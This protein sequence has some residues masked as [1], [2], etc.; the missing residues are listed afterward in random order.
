MSQETSSRFATIARALPDPASASA[1]EELARRFAGLYGLSQ[2]SNYIFGS[3]LGPFYVRG[4]HH[5]L[6]RFVYFGPHTSDESLRLAFLSG[7]DH[8]D[9]RGTFGLLHFI[10]RLAL[11][12]GLGQG[13][14]LAFF[15]LL[16]VL[17][18]ERGAENRGLAAAHWGFTRA[19]ELE[20]LEK[21]ARLRGYHGFVRVESAPGEEVVSLR[22][23]G[24]PAAAAL[25]V[26]LIS[27]EDVEPLPVRWE[28]GA[29]G[30][31]PADGPLSIADDLPFLPFELTLRIP[32][33][34]PADL[35]REAIGSILKRF[36]LRYRGHQ[37]YAQHL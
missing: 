20:L 33:A 3:P 13:L 11:E 18:L 2:R 23:R 19:P 8:R 31:L 5:P 6:P 12:P 36:V 14:N 22:L 10:E 17:G 27:S 7:F 35:H 37:A 9:L 30:F 32:A 29:A 16:D 1:S 4:R 24:H 21:D 25:G 15:P 26:E 34:W 28:A